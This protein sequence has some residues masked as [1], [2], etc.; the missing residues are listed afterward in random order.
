MP[1]LPR[2]RFALSGAERHFIHFATLT[3]RL[4]YFHYFRFSMLSCHIIFADDA[5]IIFASH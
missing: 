2:R 5:A 1:L 3:F 4:K